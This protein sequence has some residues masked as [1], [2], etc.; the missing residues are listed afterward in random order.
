MY[1]GKQQIYLE[2]LSNKRIAIVFPDDY[3]LLKY[4]IKLITYIDNIFNEIKTFQIESTNEYG[5]N[6][7]RI[8]SI[9]SEITITYNQE[10]WSEEDEVGL[11][12]FLY[13]TIPKCQNFDISTNIDTIEKIDFGKYIL[14]NGK[15]EPEAKAYKINIA[16]TNINL[17]YNDE[18]LNLNN[19]YSYD[20][21]FFNTGYTEGNFETIYY[22]YNENGY[23]D[24]NSCKITYNIKVKEEVEEEIIKEEEN[25]EELEKEEE[26]MR[27]KGNEKEEEIE[28]MKESEEE[29][30]DN[31]RN[32]N[33]DE[34]RFVL[35]Y[36][37]IN[38]LKVNFKKNAINNVIFESNAYKIHFYNT[39]KISQKKAENNS[40]ISSIDLMTCET[41]LKKK[42]NI[43]EEE[44][45]III[46]VDIEI[47]DS[48]SFQVEYEIYSEALNKLNLDYFSGD[49]IKISIPY[50]LG[51]DLLKKVKLGQNQGYDIL[52]GNSSFYSDICTPFSSEFSTDITLNDRKKYYY[53]PEL[54]CENNCTYISYNISNSKVDCECPVKVSM[55]FDTTKRSFDTNKL[56][57]SF[58][59]KISNTNF[60][61]IKCLKKG[62]QN[63]IS[64]AC[65]WLF[66]LSIICHIVCIL[67]LFILGPIFMNMNDSFKKEIINEINMS[68]E[69]MELIRK[70]SEILYQ[71]KDV[72][73][74]NINNEEENQN[75]IKSSDLIILDRIKNNKD[76]NNVQI[77]STKKLE[78]FDKIENPLSHLE[79]V[80]S[81]IEI[82]EMSYELSLIYVKRNY[83]QSYFSLIKNYQLFM[84]TFI[85]KEKYNLFFVELLVFEFFI[86]LLFIINLFLFTD[87][88]FS[89][90][91]EKKG[92][93]DF[94][95]E[96]PKMLASSIICTVLNLGIKLLM[97]NQKRI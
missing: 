34:Q 28:E 19:L 97:Y 32:E 16:T 79:K 35:I 20:K 55:N 44:V 18:I 40:R 87:S 83:I 37:K 33:E 26:I 48:K 51:E 54:F 89:Y 95:Y 3:D 57:S 39:S 96:F 60:K 50:N 22:V 88:N 52:N 49:N 46:E 56:N 53:S 59:K 42:Y 73:I 82:N 13:L 93:Y 8:F 4:N 91:Y 70:N 5:I 66:L 29:K 71:K 31:E 61:I 47:E 94:G 24:G 15:I 92:K 90:Y 74:K 38:E 11:T 36:N 86:S 14:D 58:K 64:N 63:F 81:D 30:I 6:S 72:D 80:F 43:P 12:Y 2:K 85:I 1:I 27:E 25:K 7:I 84:F 75:N 76:D 9:N 77:H 23:G 65:A 10:D 21:I 17:Y 68:S 69:K 67:I 41:T 62:F 78:T 45:L